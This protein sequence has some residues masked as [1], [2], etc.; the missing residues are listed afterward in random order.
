M[1][2]NNLRVLIFLF[3]RH[4]IHFLYLNSICIFCSQL[5]F[6][7]FTHLGCCTNVNNLKISRNFSSIRMCVITRPHVIFGHSIWC[8]IPQKWLF[9]VPW[10]EFSHWCRKN[11]KSLS[12]PFSEYSDMWTSTL[13]YWGLCFVAYSLTIPL[14]RSKA[15]IHDVSYTKYLHVTDQKRMTDRLSHK[16]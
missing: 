16:H 6:L 7:I 15:L 9:K 13:T 4:E 2:L 5:F 10:L 12:V 14:D 3:L 8:S 11:A 1:Y